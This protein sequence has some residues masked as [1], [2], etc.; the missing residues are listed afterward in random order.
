MITLREVDSKNWHRLAKLKVAEGQLSFVAPNAISL[1]QAK[2]EQGMTPLGIYFDEEPVGFC[3]Y[4]HFDEG[5]GGEEWIIRLMV[6]ERF[7]SKG[8]GRRAMERLIERIRAEAGEKDILLSF[9]PENHLARR[10]YESMGFEPDGRVIDGETVYR[11]K[12]K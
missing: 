12:A 2:Y 11:L 1:A 5:D 8:Y 9:E 6:D 7:Q 10:L 3:M 4:G